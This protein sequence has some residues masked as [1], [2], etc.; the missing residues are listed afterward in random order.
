MMLINDEIMYVYFIL[1]G[2]VI[3]DILEMLFE[4]VRF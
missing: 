3:F 4:T 2:Q 1:V